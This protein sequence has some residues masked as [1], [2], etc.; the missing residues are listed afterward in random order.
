MYTL[1]TLGIGAADEFSALAAIKRVEERLRDQLSH[2]AG[3]PSTTDDRAA[4]G[5]QQLASF[6]A[7]HMQRVL[8]GESE[9]SLRELLSAD[10]I[11]DHK[12]DSFDDIL[13]LFGLFL[14]FVAA[15]RRWGASVADR[16]LCAML[17]PVLGAGGPDA[18]DVY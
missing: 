4:A 14:V 13:L 8:Q 18:A 7:S 17:R 11:P 10:D 16:I 12:R 6:L 9:D 2:D 15:R 5:V 3:L 1:E